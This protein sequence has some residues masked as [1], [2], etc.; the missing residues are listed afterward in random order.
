MLDLLHLFCNKSMAAARRAM[1][2][3]FLAYLVILCFE[4][5][6]PKQNTVSYLKSNDWPP[7]NF[8]LTTSLNE[9]QWNDKLWNITFRLIKLCQ[10]TWKLNVIHSFKL[11]R[12]A[13][14]KITKKQDVRWRFNFNDFCAR[15]YAKGVGV[16]NP[17]ELDILQKL[18]PAQRKLI[19]FAYVLLVNLST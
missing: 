2:P 12:R 8:G 4:K 1:A 5:R 15:A 9:S 13:S 11:N 14:I 3:T 7:T 10:Q 16:K 17:L 19:V 18:L 6:C